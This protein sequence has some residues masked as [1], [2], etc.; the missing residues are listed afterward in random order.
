MSSTTEIVTIHDEATPTSIGREFTR[1]G[2]GMF[3]LG[4]ALGLVLCGWRL[5]SK[6]FLR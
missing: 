4:F 1:W 3:M 2:L 5:Q 6:T